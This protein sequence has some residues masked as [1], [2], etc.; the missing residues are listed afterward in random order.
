MVSKEMTWDL[1][2]MVEFDDPGYISE[3]LNALVKVAEEFR[4][5][6]RGKIEDY[7]AKQVFDMLEQGDNLWLEYEG[8][9]KFSYL[10]YQ[11]DMSDEVAKKLFEKVRQTLMQVQQT[12][13]FVELELG[14][15]ISRTPEIIEDPELTEF[16]HQLE[17]IQRRIPHMLSEELEQTII[18]KDLNGIQAWNKMFGDWLATRTFSIEVNG[19]MRTM[20]YG[21]IVGLY[22][23][24]DRDLRKLAN[25]VVYETL[26]KD[27]LLWS[28][29]MLSIFKDHHQ[30]AKLR[31]WATPMSQSLIANDVDDETIKAL[32]TTIE[33]NVGVLQK[34]L[35]LKAKVMGFDKLANWDITAP[36]P[37]APEKKYTW[38]ES[39]KIVVDAY[40]QFDKQ[41]GEW[42]DEMYERRHIDA[43]VRKGKTSGA[44]CA[45]WHKG[46]SAYILQSFNGTV[47]DVYTSAHELG[48]ALHAYLGT[49]AQRFSNYDIG[50]CIAETGSIFGEL[51]LTEK[52]LAEAK[53]PE[54]RQAILSIIL[55]EFGEAG[56]QVSARVFFETSIYDALED[57]KFLDAEKISNLWVAAREKIYGDAVE[58]LP[59]MRYWWTMKMHFYMPNYRYYN[60]PYVYAQ[61]FVFAMYRLYKEQGDN[62]VPKLK[63]LLAAGS[64]RSP[65]DLAADIGFDI[66]KEEFWQKGID[67]FAEFI[68]LFEE[69]L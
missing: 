18:V 65:R 51:L 25:Q 31:K 6:H 40:S 61:L 7:S 33:K 8:P 11:A 68:K 36:L 64:S 53:T 1:S 56:F 21:E 4:D 59:I 55:D 10:G 26:S 63:A 37:N 39:R 23:N 9:Y 58:W 41:S 17:K 43:E 45:T 16:K 28:S 5:Q 34:Y 30:M 29:A 38:A 13:A 57:G 14:G 20:P 22:Q 69:T 46:Q 27:A 60:Y 52:L 54:E 62:F 19:E 12:T 42:M 47:G 48:H 35:R 3:R 44:F 67:Q 66:T 32:M 2:Q 15:L 49:R 24:P 50:S